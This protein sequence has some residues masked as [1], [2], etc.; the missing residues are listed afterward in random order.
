[1]LGSHPLRQLQHP[2]SQKQVSF[3]SNNLLNTKPQKNISCSSN[4]LYSSSSDVSSL[5]QSSSPDSQFSLAHSPPL[6]ANRNVSRA[7]KLPKRFEDF[8]LDD[9]RP[10]K[11]RREVLQKVPLPEPISVSA[12]EETLHPPSVPIVPSILNPKAAPFVPAVPSTLNSQATPI[13]PVVPLTVHPNAV[14]FVP[15][16]HRLIRDELPDD[17]D[18]DHNLPSNKAEHPDEVDEVDPPTN[19]LEPYL[20]P[21]FR[22]LCDVEVRPPLNLSKLTSTEFSTLNSEIK[23]RLSEL[24]LY[25]K[26]TE[27]LSKGVDE[28]ALV[29]Y[30]T[31]LPY[32]VPNL[33]TTHRPRI[34]KQRPSKTVCELTVALASCQKRL[35]AA[36]SRSS[37]DLM[38]EL[39]SLLKLLALAKKADK[40]E[41][42]SKKQALNKKRYLANPWKFVTSLGKP[43]SPPPTFTKDTCENYLREQLSDP[44]RDEP[45]VTPEWAPPAPKPNVPYVW[46]LVTNKTISNC[47]KKRP[48]S[49]SPGPDGIPYL[50]Y[51]RCSSLLPYVKHIFKEQQ[52]Q[53]TTP[54]SNGV[55]V[56]AMVY[57]G[58]SNPTETNPTANPTN[59]RRICK[60]N[61]IG[62]LFMRML[63]TSVSNW[64]ISQ[65]IL[66]T[67]IQ[68]GFVAKFSGCIEHSQHVAAA[69]RH[70][71][72]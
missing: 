46:F 37:P 6:V 63:C 65:R 2:Q 32:S 55:G 21:N 19:D 62:K 30:N 29:V 1:M 70:A 14:P 5:A 22:Q 40:F 45:F 35:R 71:C 9:E 11:T 26:I 34:N 10:K 15:R 25:R 4:N 52:R 8:V 53:E 36:K 33:Q 41:Q 44:T 39:R 67:S 42:D 50:L 68:K 27:D 13:E 49:S 69:L 54:I 31:A 3:Q 28:F 38:K 16:H 64:A 51:K 66:N 43:R 59:F 7:K 20:P 48:N 12:C 18:E 72:S 56:A 23:D 61:T 24:D 47:L 57:K 58:A 17:V 60:S